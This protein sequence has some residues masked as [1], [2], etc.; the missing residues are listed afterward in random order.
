MMFNQKIAIEKYEIG[1]DA[2][3]FIIAEAGVNHN[4]D[5]ELAKQLI[6]EAARCGADCVKFQTFKADRIITEDA[7]K[8]HY[9]LKT[10]PPEESQFTMLKNLEMPMDAYKEII[11]CCNKEGVL[12][13]ST[14]YNVE[15][16]DFL[17]ELGVSAFKLA[18]IHVAE[19][20]FARYTAK[21]GKPII[22]STGMATLGEVDEVVRAIRE[23]GNDNLILL[24]C[25]TNYPSRLEDANLLSMQTMAKAF[26]LTVGYSD[27]TQG[28]IASVVSVGLGAKVIEKHFTLDKSLPGPD[29]STS[30][31]PDEFS[32]LVKDIRNAE[33]VLGSS[34]KEPCDIEKKNAH[35]M[36]RSIVA[37]CNIKAGSTITEEMLTFK[38]PFT[39]LSPKYFNDFIGHQAEKDIPAD[40]FIQWSD[41][42]K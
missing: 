19:P 32:Q 17:D 35:G 29:Q 33:M 11:E 13:I 39:D 18:S 22:L 30:A 42:G 8:A 25:T 15:D 2:N 28:N 37:K 3:V 4:G 38:R 1:G 23:T 26:N 20:W 5:V 24:Q 16:V 6:R 10:T 21:K 7:P 40:A 31:E 36:R 27:H 14:P 9:Q 12:F 41:I 34:L